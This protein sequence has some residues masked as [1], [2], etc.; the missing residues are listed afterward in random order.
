MKTAKGQETANGKLIT[1]RRPKH[2]E[3]AGTGLVRLGH[4]TR[5]R[6]PFGQ[7]RLEMRRGVRLSQI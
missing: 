5:E 3:R 1:S 2:P 4:R 6:F 7:I